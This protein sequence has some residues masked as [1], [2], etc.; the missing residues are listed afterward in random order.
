MTIGKKLKAALQD[1][2]S[3][4][5]PVAHLT[6][7]KVIKILREKNEL[8]QNQLA[9]ITGL[10]QPTISGL[11]NDRIVLG[12][13]RAKIL[14]KALKAHPAILVFPDWDSTKAA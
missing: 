3:T 11:E 6:T 7:G 8:S 14:A 13:A 5:K 9:D 10:T 2:F 1:D 4:I 12:V